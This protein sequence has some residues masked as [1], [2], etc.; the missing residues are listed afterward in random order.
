MV[1]RTEFIGG[2]IASSVAPVL[3]GAVDF[4]FDGRIAVVA[5]RL[6]ENAPAVVYHPD[7]AFAS[8]SVVKLLIAVAVT[9]D[10]AQSNTSWND[11]LVVK[12]EQIVG[13]SETFENAQPG[14]S[15]TYAALLAAMIAQSD[16]TA[17]NILLDRMGFDRV[18]YLSAQLGL[19]QTKIARHF[20]DFAARKAGHENMTSA[21]DMARLVRFIASD[22]VKYQRIVGAMMSQEDRELIPASIQRR[23]IIANKTGTLPD[24]RH[25]VAIVGFNSPAP[26]VLA[27]LSGGFADMKTAQ[28]R[29]RAIAAQVD[30]QMSRGA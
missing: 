6:G 14:S 1:T 9:Q 12:K 8:A 13:A 3:P 4:A 22:P 15:A 17:A 5:Q 7:D 23:V 10:L 25:D 19:P 18:N 21:G 28:T 26:Y 29:I 16:N 11:T 24:V 20:M 27:I 30:A 2:L